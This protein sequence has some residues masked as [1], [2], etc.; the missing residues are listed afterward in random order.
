MAPVSVRKVGKVSIVEQW[1]RMRYNV[2]Q[3]VPVM[4][5]LNWTLN[6]AFAI[7]NGVEM[8]VQRNSVILIADLMAAVS[9]RLAAATIAGAASSVTQ[10][11]V[12]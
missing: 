1:I 5:R 2:C 3:T 11:C 12:I 9:E 8:T 4:E 10:S 7:Q 6:L